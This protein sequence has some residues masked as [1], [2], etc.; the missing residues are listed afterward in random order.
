M[1]AKGWLAENGIP[2]P[3]G[4]LVRTAAE[5]VAAAAELPGAAVLK[6]VSPRL[7]HKSDVGG[8]Q[9]GIRGSDAVQQA[10]ATILESVRRLAPD[11]DVDGVLVEEM[12]EDVALEVIIGVHVDPVFGHVLTVGAGG[13]LV[14]LL[15]DVQRRLLPIDRGAA[16][17]MV[18]QLRV[19]PLLNG[20]RGGPRLDLDALATVLARVSD[21]VVAH[22]EIE[23]L[24]LNPVVLRPA[25]SGR[26]SVVAVDA[27]VQ[28]VQR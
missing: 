11:V 10:H 25:T 5:A 27:V 22:P 8:V 3:R 18:E 23:Q 17:E 19:A 4:R 28:V 20:H 15:N 12:I 21:L 2:V 7:A 14:E 26:S 6:I 9:V 24:E 1:D 13:V 16:G